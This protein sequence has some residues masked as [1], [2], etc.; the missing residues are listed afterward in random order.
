MLRTALPLHFEVQRSQVVGR[1]LPVGLYHHPL[2]SLSPSS[3]AAAVL[4]GDAGS[5]DALAV[6]LSA[7]S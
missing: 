5:E 6:Q 3:S 7:A 1:L 2:Q 4:H